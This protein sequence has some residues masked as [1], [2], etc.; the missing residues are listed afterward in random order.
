MQEREFHREEM[1]RETAHKKETKKKHPHRK[2]IHKKHLHKDRMQKTGAGKSTAEREK[3]LMPD[4]PEEWLYLAP[5]GVSLRSIYDCLKEGKRWRAEYW[6][7][8]GVM[9]ISIP[10]AGSVDVEVM[11]IDPEDTKLCSY[12][13][14]QKLKAVYAV[15]IM[16]EYFAEAQAVMQYTLE[17]IGGIFCGDTED[18]LPEERAASGYA[19]A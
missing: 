8:A 12:M 15:T 1:R 6:D 19:E 7:E 13:E 5:E 9:E 14:M 3:Q 17:T 2:E 10:E 11:E 18:L 16:P 4:V